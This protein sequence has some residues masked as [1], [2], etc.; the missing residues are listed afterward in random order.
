MIEKTKIFEHTNHTIWVA[1]EN[2]ISGLNPQ[3]HTCTICHLSGTA[4]TSKNTKE[5]IECH[6][7]DM[8]IAH[9]ASLSPAFLYAD[10][11][12]DAMHKNCITCHTN[13]KTSLNKPN[14]NQCS[15]CH[16]TLSPNNKSKKMITKYQ[17]GQTEIT[18]K[19]NYK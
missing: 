16:K 6:N 8:N 19:Y 17:E 9:S 2:Q 11:F 15:S 5:C 7:K 14:L 4:K 3:N 1:K 13:Q 18:S 10:S 12:M